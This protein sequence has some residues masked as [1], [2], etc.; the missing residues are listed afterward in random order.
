MAM[1]GRG[2]GPVYARWPAALD[3]K[4][5]WILKT[6][7]A[8]GPNSGSPHPWPRRTGAVKRDERVSLPYVTNPGHG[9]LRIRIR[10]VIMV[11]RTESEPP[12]PTP[13][14]H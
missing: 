14:P 1:T 8:C 6:S 13:A 7:G 12:A 3:S 9:A 4:A 2:Q 10:R 11:G 5:F